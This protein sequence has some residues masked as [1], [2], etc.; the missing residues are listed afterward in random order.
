MFLTDPKT[1]GTAKKGVALQVVPY[2]PAGEK[3]QG[4]VFAPYIPLSYFSICFFLFFSRLPSPLSFSSYLLRPST[5]SI[6][7]PP[8]L[9][10]RSSFLFLC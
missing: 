8:H 4:I 1:N 6:I 5:R 3:S 2:R 9:P 7:F 10:A